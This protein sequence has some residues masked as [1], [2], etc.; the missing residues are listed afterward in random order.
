MKS[1]LWLILLLLL[2][3]IIVTLF[4][5][6]YLRIIYRDFKGYKTRVP[7]LYMVLDAEIMLV[8]Y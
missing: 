6:G 4:M 2:E 3:L 5:L 7:G 1:N 8:D